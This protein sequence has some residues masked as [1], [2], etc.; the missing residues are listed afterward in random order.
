[1][2]LWLL[3]FEFSE[4][5]CRIKIA[6]LG[7]SKYFHFDKLFA[8]FFTGVPNLIELRVWHIIVKID[9]SVKNIIVWDSQS[10]MPE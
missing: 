5:N 10:C 4:T 2:S 7:K 6:Q 8:I 1:M 3:Y 9:H